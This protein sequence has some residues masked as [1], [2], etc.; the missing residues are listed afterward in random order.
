[1]RRTRSID[2]E[3]RDFHGQTPGFLKIYAYGQEIFKGRRLGC[4]RGTWTSLLVMSYSLKVML[5]CLALT[6]CII[7]VTQ[8]LGLS[9]AQ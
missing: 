4:G 8:Q 5:F 3:C 1:M 6:M 7:G 2:R 9:L